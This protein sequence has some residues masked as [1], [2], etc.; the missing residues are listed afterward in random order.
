MSLFKARLPTC[1]KELI[2]IMVARLSVRCHWMDVREIRYLRLFRKSVEKII[3]VTTK[4]IHSVLHSIVAAN[5][6][7]S[8]D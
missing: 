5:V 4:V 8:S 6:G 7:I 2:A 3:F 1:L